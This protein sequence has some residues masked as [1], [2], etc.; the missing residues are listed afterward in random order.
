MIFNLNPDFT[1]VHST[2]FPGNYPG[3]DDTWDLDKFKKVL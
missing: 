2:N 1:Q 3:Y